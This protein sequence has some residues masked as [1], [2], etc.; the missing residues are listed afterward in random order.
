MKV[1]ILVGNI[2]FCQSFPRKHIW[3]IFDLN[4]STYGLLPSPDR[5]IFKNVQYRR[6]WLFWSEM[7]YSVKVSHENISE[8]IWREY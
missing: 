1:I 8:N 3:K 2:L 4:I 6:K 5:L 7:S